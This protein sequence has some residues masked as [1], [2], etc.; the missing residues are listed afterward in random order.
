MITLVDITTDNLHQFQSDILEIENFSFPS[1]WSPKAFLEEM[2]RTC[3]YLWA[4]ITDQ[5]VAGYICFWMLTGKIHLLNIAVHP[6]KRGA[7]LG[8]YL[9]NRMIE[10]GR[11]NGIETAWLE[12]RPSNKRAIVFYKRAGFRETGRRPLYYNDTNEDAIVM[13]LTVSSRV[14]R[15]A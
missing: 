13:A 4:L 15:A 6:E 11:S 10:K 14:E 9:L 12:V 1:P 7:G 2:G 8:R 5:G 3:S